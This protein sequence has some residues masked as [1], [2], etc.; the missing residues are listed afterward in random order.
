MS[1]YCPLHVSVELVISF[2]PQAEREGQT[3]YVVALL[4]SG[5]V[6]LSNQLS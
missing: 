6:K 3:K 2:I 4:G 1:V 5:P